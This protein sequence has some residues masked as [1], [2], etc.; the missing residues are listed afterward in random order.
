MRSPTGEND[1][2]AD[3][4]AN[5][6]AF[7]IQA[8]YC[9]ANE[10]PITA[11]VCEALVRSLDRGTAVG[12]TVLDWPGNPVA[13]GLALRLVGGLH[14]LA[15]SG[16]AAMLGTLFAGRMTDAGARAAIVAAALHKHDAVLRPWLDSPPQTNE[17]GR[18][19]GLMAGL[20]W[21]ASRFPLPIELIE[22][23]S[24][25][26]LNLLIDRFAFNLGG[27]RAG[28]AKSPVTIEPE[29]RGA[30]PPA[31]SVDIASVRG[32][33]IAPI[34]VLDDAQATRLKGYVWA[35]HPMR[36]DRVAAAIEMIREKPVALEKG[37]AADWVEARLAKR[38]PKG[39]MRVLMHSIM[40]QYLSETAKA[41]IE[42]A[43][44]AAG[45]KANADAPLAWVSLEAD[46]T[47]NR[48]DLTVRYWPGGAEPIPL[49]HAHAHGFWVEWGSGPAPQPL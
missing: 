23:G 7:Q 12:R 48:H 1:K 15:R 19:A 41:R 30:P 35:D 14:A 9:H 40:W 34:D 33:D 36:F 25:A 3:E 42:A 43:M 46:R 45:A 5:R 28:P 31:A 32:V 10:A 6:D 2:M 18:S 20:L 24:S 27:V 39:T 37:D 26:G 21:L 47:L 17:P 29:W 4:A 16:N 13:D 11:G 38:Q 49:A 22:I 8:N 44:A